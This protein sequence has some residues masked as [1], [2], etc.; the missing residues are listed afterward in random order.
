MSTRGNSNSKNCCIVINFILFC[1]TSIIGIYM[2]IMYFRSLSL[3]Q[4]E[5]TV[6]NVIYPT[7]L[8][9]NQSDMAGFIDCDCG[10]RCISDLGI[11]IS[12][13]G[14][15]INSNN[16]M[17]F[18]DNFNYVDN[19]CTYQEVKCP[20][21]ES[22]Q[23]RLTAINEAGDIAEQYIEKM[24]T[25]VDC[26]LDESTSELYFSDEFNKDAAFAVFGLFIF[27]TIALICLCLCGNSKQ[28][29]QTTIEFNE[30]ESGYNNN[31][32]ENN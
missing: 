29:N 26:Y 24:N 25:T 22:I 5:C 28:K 6:T 3:I 20:Q 19:Q 13:Y 23:D 18:L 27:F 9:H 2:L 1:V 32:K 11:C 14:N 21:G 7:R 4:E 15:I 12:V 31:S 16:T 10:R 8:P 17:M 30:I